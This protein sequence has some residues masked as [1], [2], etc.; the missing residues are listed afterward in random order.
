MNPLRWDVLL[1]GF[2]LALPVLA[3]GLRGDL[4]ADEVMVRLPWCLAAGWGAVA[5]LRMASAPRT[6]AGATSGPKRPER[7]AREDEPAA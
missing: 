1:V 6:P 3:L 7:P 5:L 4:S 2:V